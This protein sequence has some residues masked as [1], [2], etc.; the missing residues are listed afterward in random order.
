MKLLLI[1]SLAFF[2][3]CGHQQASAPSSSLAESAIQRGLISTIT[4]ARCHGYASHLDLNEFHVEIATG[5]DVALSPVGRIPAIKRECGTYC[6]TQ[7]DDGTGHILVSG[8]YDRGADK[9]V[10]AYIQG[11]DSALEEAAGNEAEH[12]ILFFND[13]AKYQE[14]AVHAIGQGHPIIPACQ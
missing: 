3:S 14:T 11:Y 12:E 4:K 9:I 8:Y 5:S 10:L 7:W 13:S 2:Y 1:I 6:G